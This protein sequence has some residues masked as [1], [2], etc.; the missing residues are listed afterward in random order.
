MTEMENKSAMLLRS[1]QASKAGMFH[2][3][4][5]KMLTSQSFVCCLLL[6]AI[7]SVSHDNGVWSSVTHAKSQFVRLNQPEKPPEKVKWSIGNEAP[8][9]CL[10]TG[11][12]Y[13]L[14]NST[15]EM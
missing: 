7:Q 15:V 9:A 11:C 14:D 5:C 10:A 12:L 3:L 8:A 2:G 1:K 4:H 6:P 13:C